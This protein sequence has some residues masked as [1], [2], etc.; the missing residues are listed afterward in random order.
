VKRFPLPSATNLS[1]QRLVPTHPETSFTIIRETKFHKR[2]RTFKDLRSAG[3]LS[4]QFGTRV[5]CFGD[6]HCLHAR[7]L[8]S[9]SPTRLFSHKRLMSSTDKLCAVKKFPECWYCTVTVGHRNGH[10]MTSKVGPLGTQTCSID[11]AAVVSTSRRLLL[12][13][14]GV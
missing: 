6:L 3:S 10:L 4:G 13:S 14:S 11:P 5:L 9:R 7:K 12:E 1:P 8:S 2:E